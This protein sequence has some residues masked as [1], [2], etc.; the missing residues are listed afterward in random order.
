MIKKREP[1][2]VKASEE[3]QNLLRNAQK[4]K[5]QETKKEWTYEQIVVKVGCSV[6]TVKR[7]FA[8]KNVN[9]DYAKEIVKTLGL[10]FSDVVDLSQSNIFNN[11]NTPSQKLKEALFD[12][13]YIDQEYH[14]RRSLGQMESV[15]AF[16]IHGEKG[17]GQRW[18]V[19][20]LAGLIPYN[21]TAY[22]KPLNIPHKK[23]LLDFW[24]DMGESIKCYPNP[25]AIAEQLYQQWT[26][27]TVILS[28]TD[29]HK[30]DQGLESFLE[31]VWLRVID[32][33]NN[34]NSSKNPFK[35]ILFI[36]GN[37]TFNSPS[38]LLIDLT[39]IQDFKEGVIRTWGGAQ[40][41]NLLYN[42]STE[43]IEGC[44]EDIIEQNSLPIFTLEQICESCSINYYSDI[45][46]SFTL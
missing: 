4:S 32:K 41:P 30:V 12:L 3:G 2:R 34:H 23:P 28:I 33:I 24:E 8:G 17:Y 20:R 37:K 36:V 27:R 38:N 19:N 5:T 6:D 13:N 25:E 21:S 15:G 35:M 22:Q 26:T 46:R 10:E 44:I 7:F 31:R 16:L 39:P 18:L 14:F 43:Q 42:Y 11:S 9:T 45:E 1:R 29:I 40:L